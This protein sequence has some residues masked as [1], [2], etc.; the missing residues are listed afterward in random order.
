VIKSALCNRADSGVLLISGKAGRYVGG[1]PVCARPTPEWQKGISSF[2]KKVPD[3]DV[4]PDAEDENQPV[5]GENQPVVEV[6]DKAVASGS[7]WSLQWFTLLVYG[8]P[9]A[10]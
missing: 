7:R 2:M 6:N 10:Q 1:N 9:L 5:D 8:T 3:K 4:K